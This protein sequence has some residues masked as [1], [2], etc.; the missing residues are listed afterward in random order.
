[1][2]NCLPKVDNSIALSVFMIHLPKKGES[3]Y[4]LL[5]IRIFNNVIKRGQMK[6]NV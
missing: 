3:I 2:K 1:M 4:I 5:R 6:H